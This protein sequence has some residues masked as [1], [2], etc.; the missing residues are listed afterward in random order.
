MGYAGRSVL[1]PPP[2]VIAPVRLVAPIADHRPRISLEEVR[3]A[4]RPAGLPTGDD[5]LFIDL[6]GPGQPVMSPAEQ[7]QAIASEVSGYLRYAD[8][9]RRLGIFGFAPIPLLMALGR[10]IGDKRQALVFE[11]HRHTDDWRWGTVVPSAA[12]LSVG[13]ELL[14]EPSG[15][16][17][18]LVSV[19]DHVKRDAVRAAIGRPF[20]VY[21]IAA[22]QP[23][24]NVIRTPSQLMEFSQTWRR[25]LDMAHERVGHGGRVHV[26]AAAPLSVS[27]EM[28]RRLLPHADPSL[29]VYDYR[30]GEF[31]RTIEVG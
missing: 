14:P 8:G 10:A 29:L 20:D 17:A 21:S 16:V 15:D 11:R 24:V 19:S 12:A 18:L 13:D 26:F 28:G 2:G 31:V 27:V 22:A 1:G 9:S 23:R 6:C 5:G 3:S 7:A 25:V 4:C 30:K